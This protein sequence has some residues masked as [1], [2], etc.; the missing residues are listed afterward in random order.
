M[1]TSFHHFS[2]EAGRAILQNAVDAGEGMGIFEVTRRSLSSIPLILGWVLLLVGCTPWIRPFRWSRLFWTF[3]IPVIP[4]V[5]LFDGMVS[6]LRTYRPEELRQI[7]SGVVGND[8]CWEIGE[9][10][11]GKVP[12]VYLIGYPKSV[13]TAIV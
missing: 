11:S 2:P 12:I 3:L 6:C 4:A 13:A 10:S 8:Y 9:S 7:L 1:F 5:L